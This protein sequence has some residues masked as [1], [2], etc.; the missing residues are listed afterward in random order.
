MKIERAPRY[1]G[2]I[3]SWKDEQGFGFIAPNGGGPTVFVHIK[4]ILDRDGR[5]A[6]DHIVTYELGTNDKG[7]PRAENV[8]FVHAPATRRAAAEPTD[9]SLLIASGFLI[10]LFIAVL[11][12]KLP[13]P[14]FACYLGLSALTF[15]AYAIDKSAARNNR[16]RTKES[17]L[18]LL[19]LIG[20]WPGALVAQR[21][22]RHKS[23][24]EAFRAA[25]WLT[26]IVNCAALGWLVFAAGRNVQALLGFA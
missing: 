20:G 7:Q 17:T 24:K 4:S 9:R 11:A 2:K 10:L 18:H 19:A 6:S 26:A 25:F 22:L 3:T 15:V 5:P 8:R 13:A 21:V 23:K 1:Q 12:R 14:V 16:W